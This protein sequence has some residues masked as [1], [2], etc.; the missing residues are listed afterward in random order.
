MN[1]H[2]GQTGSVSDAGPEAP[3][4]I[5]GLPSLKGC[6]CCPLVDMELCHPRDKELTCQ[7]TPGGNGETQTQV[8]WTLR[9]DIDT[10]ERRI[11]RQK[12]KT[13]D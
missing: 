6:A 1:R 5:P 3:E 4:S 2:S 11:E 12:V 9:P 13:E 8:K 10:R 7:S